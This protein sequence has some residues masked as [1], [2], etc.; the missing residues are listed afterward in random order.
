MDKYSQY[1]D[2][3]VGRLRIESDEV[4]GSYGKGFPTVHKTRKGDMSPH[5]DKSKWNVAFPG[6][7]E[8]IEWFTA[9]HPNE[10]LHPQKT[11]EGTLE[12]IGKTESGRKFKMEFRKERD[13]RVLCPYDPETWEPVNIRGGTSYSAGEEMYGARQNPD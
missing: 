7:M 10:K 8:S 6:G 5:P 12:A 4:P 13:A 9:D 11:P 1:F 3:Y 2:T